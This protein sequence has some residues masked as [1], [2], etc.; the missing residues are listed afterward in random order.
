MQIGGPVAG[1]HAKLLNRLSQG[2]QQQKL[3]EVNEKRKDE[4][5]CKIIH[6]YREM[7]TD[8]DARWV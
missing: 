8:E 6:W 7:E 4:A 2:A 5:S 1:K 3:D